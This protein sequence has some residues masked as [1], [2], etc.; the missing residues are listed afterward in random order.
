MLKKKKILFYID[1][2]AQ[3]G[4]DKV[5]TEILNNLNFDKYEVTLIRRFPGGYYTNFLDSHIITKSN[6]PFKEGPIM[7]RE[8]IIMTYII[9]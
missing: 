8:I 7:S 9:P 2:L 4:L 3:G 6:M 5:V 1:T